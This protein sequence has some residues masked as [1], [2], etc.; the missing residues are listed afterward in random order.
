MEAR[1]MDFIVT[2]IA[3]LLALA[4]T[5][6]VALALAR[7]ID[8]PSWIVDRLRL[9]WRRFTRINLWHVMAVVAVLALM[10]ATAEAPGFWMLI[11]GFA[12][13]VVFARAWIKQ[14]TFLMSL[15]DRDFPGRFDKIVWTFLLVFLAPVGY[16][17]FR[18]YRDSHWPEP[19][20][21]LETGQAIKASPAVEMI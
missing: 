5:A 20:V 12:L 16:W 7:A 3:F 17:T 10:L 15:R 11:A 13:V 1:L 6:T 19:A 9:I 8:H 2:A 4:V 18:A 21:D 14:M